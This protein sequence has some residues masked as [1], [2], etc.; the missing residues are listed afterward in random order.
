MGG[1]EFA[2]LLPEAADGGLAVIA[3]K[4]WHPLA[5]LFV[6][7]SIGIAQFPSDCGTMDALM[8]YADSAMYHAKKQGRNNFQ[9]YASELTPRTSE[10]L[11]L[12][13]ALRRALKN[14]EF[15]LYYQP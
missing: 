4:I 14:V 3:D 15:E 9:F 11:E 2:L 13:A 7:S 8:Q 6:S 10:G 5:D 12:E 1:D